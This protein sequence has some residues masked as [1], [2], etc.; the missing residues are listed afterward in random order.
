MTLQ[1]RWLGSVGKVRALVEAN[2]SV[3]YELRGRESAY[4]F[5]REQLRRLAYRGLG[6][7]D[8]GNLRRFLAKMAELSELSMAGGGQDRGSA[9]PRTSGC[10][11]RSTRRSARCPS[12]PH[13]SCSI[14]RT[15]TC[16]E[17]LAG[18]S[19]RFLVP[20]L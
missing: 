13:S 1:T 12:R 11:P 8:R 2:Q 19:E 5:V 6:T 7:R 4:A 3:D 10:W 14:D 9:L 17:R 20:L 18:I 16:I 15:D